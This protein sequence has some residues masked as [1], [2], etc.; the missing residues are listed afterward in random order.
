[1][2]ANCLFFVRLQNETLAKVRN[3]KA[4]A[5]L[6]A[7]NTVTG[8]SQGI[9]LIAIPWFIANDLNKPSLFGVLFFV[10]TLIA[11][12]WGPYAGTLVDKYDRKKVMM[13]IQS[14]G[15]LLVS[16]IA[17]YG[18]VTAHSYLWMACAVFLTTKILYNIHYP[19]LYAFAQEITEAKHYGR[20]TSWLEVQGQTTFTIAGAAAAFLLEG[21][22][23]NW[24]FGKWEIYEIFMLD[25]STYLVAILLLSLIKYTS[26]AERNKGKLSFVE[27]LKFGFQYLIDRRAIFI[28]GVSAGF[29]FASI[30]VTNFFTLP[31]FIKNY[32][33]ATERIYGL[34]EGAFALGS[35]LS[36]ILIISII[37]KNKLVMGIISLSVIAGALFAFLSGNKIVA[38]LLVAYVA[39]GFCNAGIRILRTTYIFNV[40][41]NNIIGRTSGVFMVANSLLRLF[42]IALFSV[43]FFSVESNIRFTF[44][45]LSFFIFMGAIILL[46]NYRKLAQLKSKLVDEK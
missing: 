13:S 43:P 7:A 33:G 6:F 40:I 2:N 45:I 10:S 18:F 28:F 30:L 39:V 24:H 41:P 29:V 38:L 32:I 20:I 11:I 42:F 31:I 9:S 8:V 27:R 37:P 5:L 15:F 17:V 23:G 46:L 19:N 21:Q 25:A 36:G 16:S 26:L 1:M 12:F 4:I 35:L 44:L 34:S 22:I 14:V 3:T